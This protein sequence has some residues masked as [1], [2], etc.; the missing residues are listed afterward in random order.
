MKILD[1]NGIIFRLLRILCRKNILAVFLLLRKNHMT[2]EK[3]NVDSLSESY[4]VIFKYDVAF[5]TMRFQP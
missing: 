5:Y 3:N 2:Y 4:N 1:V